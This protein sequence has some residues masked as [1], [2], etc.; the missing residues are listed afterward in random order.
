MV[1]GRLALVDEDQPL[2][3]ISVLP[4]GAQRGAATLHVDAAVR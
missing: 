2:L 4:A 1:L 3:G